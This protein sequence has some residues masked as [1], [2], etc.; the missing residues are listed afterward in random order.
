MRSQATIRQYPEPDESIP[1]LIPC[2]INNILPSTPRYLK[3]CFPLRSSDENFCIFYG[4]RRH[5]SLF[6]DTINILYYSPSIIRMMKSRR[7]GRVCSTIGGEEEC[8]R[9][10]VGKRKGRRPLWRPRC[11]WVNNIKI[12]LREIGWDGMYS[13]DPVPDRDQWKAL[14]NTVMNLRVP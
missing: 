13:I 1:H 11:R 8:M 3:T 14:V 5:E 9:I 7:M 12:D 4:C 2:F 10:L 6:C